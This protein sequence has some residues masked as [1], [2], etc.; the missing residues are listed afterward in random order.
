MPLAV[1]ISLIM[2]LV[3]EI[4]Y[5]RSRK[6]APVSYPKH[7]GSASWGLIE[8]SDPKGTYV[9]STTKWTGKYNDVY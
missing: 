2:K 1:L 4:K 8:R 7:S 6:A 5:R 3:E 9:R